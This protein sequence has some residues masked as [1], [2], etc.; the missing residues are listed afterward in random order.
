[1]T[2]AVVVGSGPNGLAGAIR[3]ARA[4]LEVTVLEAHDRPGGGTR[5]SELTLPGVLH[6][7]CAAF[8]PTGVASPWF[9]ALGLERHGLRWRWPEVDLAH[10]L[11]DGRAGI[12][13]RDMAATV[14][15]LGRDGPHW[16]RIFAPVVRRF[17][18]PDGR[19]PPTRG[20]RPPA[21]PRA[22]PLRHEGTAARH[23]GRGPVPRRPRTRALHRGRRAR[24]PP[25]RHPAQQRR[26]ADAHRHRPRRGLAGRRGRLGVDHPGPACRARRARRHRPHGHPRPLAGGACASTRAERRTSC[27]STRHRRA[28]S[29]SSATGCP[30]GCAARWSATPTAP[31]RSRSTSPSRGTSPG[32]TRTSAAPAPSTSAVRRSRSPPSSL[33]TTRGRMPEQPYVLLGQQYLADPS[34]SSAAA[35]PVYA[36]AH[37]PRGYDGD[38]TDAVIGQVERFAPGFRDRVLAVSTR[39][40]GDWEAYNPNYVGGDIAAGANTALQTAFRPRPALNPYSLGVAG[41]YLCSAATPPGAGVHGMG[42]FHAAEAC[43]ET[44]CLGLTSAGDSTLGVAR[45]LVRPRP[46]PPRH[47]CPRRAGAGRHG[48]GERHRHV[49]GRHAGCRRPGPRPRHHHRQAGAQRRAPTAATRSPGSRPAPTCSRPIP[50][51]P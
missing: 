46:R 43:T 41:V 28:P 40:P 13:T 19:G 24:L 42:G 1:M 44:A 51:A 20:A 33:A 49:A 17:D 11:D 4:G 48:H 30:G 14:A 7:D 10:P 32:P 34:R 45:R 6:D 36:Y 12:A 31:Q 39:R 22:R 8:H 26:R 29:R 37:V 50:T 5:T 27:C 18:E 47:A 9:T 21:P 23:L 15:S 16:E 35:N 25:S 3:L 38:A 2:T